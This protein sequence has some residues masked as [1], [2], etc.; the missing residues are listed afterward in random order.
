[1]YKKSIWGMRYI[2]W[3]TRTR[4]PFLGFV[5]LGIGLLL[6]LMLNT[7]ISVIK[8]YCAQ[9]VQTESQTA[10]MIGTDDIMDAI[11]Y[12]YSNK[13]EAVYTVSIVKTENASQQTLLY[14]DDNGQ[15]ALNALSGKELFIDIPQRKE[16]LLYQIF[17][18]GG[19]RRE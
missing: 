4:W 19:N 9:V 13:N 1:M 18:K 14:F 2:R 16:S 3:M 6:S 7:K 12:I 10:V 5:V 15:K 8:T 11:G 17:V